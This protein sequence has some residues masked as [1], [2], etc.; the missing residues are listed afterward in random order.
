MR[1]SE[2]D[3]AASL[4]SVVAIRRSAARQSVSYPIRLDLTY[5][6]SR[7]ELIKLRGRTI[8]FLTMRSGSPIQRRPRPLTVRGREVIRVDR[9]SRGGRTLRGRQK[10]NAEGVR[11]TLLEGMRLYLNLLVDSMPFSPFCRFYSVNQGELGTRSALPEDPLSR[12]ISQAPSCRQRPK[13]EGLGDFV[14]VIRVDRNSWPFARLGN[15]EAGLSE[16]RS[17]GL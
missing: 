13:A 12:R 16:V 5:T 6:F 11:I 4:K 9:N 10:V 2:E 8:D 1:S 3:T 15:P 14:Q 7:G 17:S